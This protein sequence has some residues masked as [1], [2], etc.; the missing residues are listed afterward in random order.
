MNITFKSMSHRVWC[1]FFTIVF[2]IGFFWAGCT[3]IANAGKEPE[4]KTVVYV[5]AKP[6]HTVII[7]NDEVNQT[8]KYINLGYQVDK[9]SSGSSGRIFIVMVKY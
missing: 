6:K 4:T 5:P 9:I 1:E 3:G 2:I 7:T 8:I